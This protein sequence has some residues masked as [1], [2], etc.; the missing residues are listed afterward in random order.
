MFSIKAMCPRVIY[1]RKGEIVFDGPTDEG[2]KL[3]ESDSR[4]A[5]S[6]WFEK[7]GA[8]APA[9]TFTDIQLIGEN[10]AEKTVFNFGERMKVRLRYE[11]SRPIR[12]PDIRIGINRSDELHCCTFSSTSD[13]VDIPEMS[14][15]GVIEIDTPPLSLVSEMYFT[16]IAVRENAK[17]IA[18]QIGAAFHMSHPVY[19]GSAWGVFHEAA[20]WRINP[21]EQKNAGQR[22]AV[23]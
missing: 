11:T 8:N 20:D 10:G 16:T 17:Q 4:L 2:L 14:G 6:P 9:I 23:G 5:V 3:Y 18:S 21:M 13:N 22:Q 1:L 19:G 15:E 12:N 7:D